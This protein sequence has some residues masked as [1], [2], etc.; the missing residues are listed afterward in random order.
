M[1]RV[2]PRWATA[3]SALVLAAGIALV[4]LRLTSGSSS[5]GIRVSDAYMPQPASPSVAAAYFTVHNS[6][7]APDTLESVSSDVAADTMLMET[8]GDTMSMSGAVTV[9]AHGL[10][11]LSPG[12]YHVMLT[13]P[14][15]RLVEGDTVQ[16]TVTF[17]HAGPITLTVPVK[18]MTYRPSDD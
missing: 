6:G 5:Q 10:F 3:G 7:G 1:T 2:I 11:R 12:G 18:S 4:V 16:L 13:D 17:A 8:T 9:P 14:D 15:R